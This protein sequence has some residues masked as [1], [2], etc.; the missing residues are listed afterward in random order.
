MSAL[1]VTGAAGLLGRFV[2]APLY[3]LTHA[4]ERLG[5]VAEHDQRHLLR[6]LPGF[7]SGERQ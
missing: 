3:D 7:A 1:L 2:F 4:A 5:F 6:G